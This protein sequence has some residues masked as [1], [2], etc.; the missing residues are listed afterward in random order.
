MLSYCLQLI[1]NKFHNLKLRQEIWAADW[2]DVVARY[3][4]TPNIF[5]LFRGWD[6]LLSEKR[7][8][9]FY[10]FF[11]LSPFFREQV[12]PAPKQYERVRGGYVSCVVGRSVR[13]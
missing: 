9:K 13:S 8:K 5:V 1:Q 4:A 10:P 12:I 11:P 3:I 7:V 6:Y 2:N